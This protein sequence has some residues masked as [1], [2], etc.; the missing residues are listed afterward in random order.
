VSFLKA[1]AIPLRARLRA[2][3]GDVE[4]PDALQRSVEDSPSTRGKINLGLFVC[5]AFLYAN[6]ISL[7]ACPNSN[8]G[9][10]RAYEVPPV[11]IWR[12]AI[13]TQKPHVKPSISIH[14]PFS[15]HD[16][17]IAGN[18]VSPTAKKDAHA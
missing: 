3:G 17:I 16:S 14:E 7:G 15:D 6:Q 18:R 2:A 12:G 13:F 4:F 10:I 1:L 11:A 9:S 8:V 5:S